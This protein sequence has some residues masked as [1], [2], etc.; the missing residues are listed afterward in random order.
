MPLIH[1]NLTVISHLAME[2][3]DYSFGG[4][5]GKSTHYSDLFLLMSVNFL[6]LP[7]YWKPNIATEHLNRFI[8][9]TTLMVKSNINGKRTLIK[10]FKIPDQDGSQ[11]EALASRGLIV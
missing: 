4:L 9:Y 8:E 3:L 11:V 7:E 10:N 5:C 6:L 2:K 1:Q